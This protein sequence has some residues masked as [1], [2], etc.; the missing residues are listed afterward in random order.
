MPMKI[1]QMR[2][3]LRLYDRKVAHKI[4]LIPPKEL[5]AFWDSFF[6]GAPDGAFEEDGEPGD[7]RPHHVDE[8][9]ERRWCK[10]AYALARG[11]KEGDEYLRYYTLDEEGEWD[12]CWKFTRGEALKVSPKSFRYVARTL[13]SDHF[14]LEWAD[15]WL[16]C[17]MSGNDPLKQARGISP[18]DDD[19]WTTYC[20]KTAEEFL[21]YLNK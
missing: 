10:R 7:W 1:W 6:G 19:E 12:E 3:Y 8:T 14:F 15:Y 21:D 2:A 17:A 9:A 20:L 4:A 16:A 11:R 13:H 5:K 18:V